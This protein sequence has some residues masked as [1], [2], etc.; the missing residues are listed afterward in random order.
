MTTSSQFKDL[1]EFLAKHS[2]KNDKGQPCT[3]TRIPDKDLNIYA[4]S[5][6][7]P[8]EE[9]PVFYSLYYDNVFNKKRKEYLT[10]R[11]SE[12][13]GPMAVDFDF[14]YNYDVDTRQHTKEHIQDMI[15]LYIET[16]KEFFL[17]EENKPF[18]IFIFEKPNVNRLEDKSVTKDGIHMVIGVQID[19]TMQLMIRDKM[20]TSLQEVWDLPLVNTWESVLDE[21]ISKG[22]TNW[23][24]FG[25]RKPGNE[26]YELT[27]HFIISYDK[28]DGEF[29]MDEKKVHDTSYLIVR[30]S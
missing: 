24:L 4:G 22:T 2:A 10:E 26:A 21:G 14:R 13:G 12:T 16:L 9:L 8:K 27:Q 25:S 19:H 6:I 23:Q 18:D 15:L 28:S 30:D 29:M 11:Q 5:Y 20:I 1:T 3:H 17:F 7:I